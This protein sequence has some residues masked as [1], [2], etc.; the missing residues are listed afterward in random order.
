MTDHLVMTFSVFV[1]MSLIFCGIVTSQ[2]PHL[3]GQRI[4]QEDNEG[5]ITQ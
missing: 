5:K 3:T 2:S 1:D 4:T